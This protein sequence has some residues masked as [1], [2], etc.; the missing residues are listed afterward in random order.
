ML[1]VCIRSYLKSVLWYKFLIVDDYSPDNLHL[2]EEGWE[3]CGYFSKPNEIREQKQSE[4]HW[5]KWKNYSIPTS[6][7]Y[8]IIFQPTSHSNRIYWNTQ[9]TTFS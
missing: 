1:L 2:S 7:E 5:Y 6:W 8:G 9:K 3:D 4:K